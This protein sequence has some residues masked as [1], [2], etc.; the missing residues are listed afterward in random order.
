MKY[1]IDRVLAQLRYLAD[2]AGI[3]VTDSSAGLRVLAVIALVAAGAVVYQVVDVTTQPTQPYSVHNFKVHPRTV[4]QPDPTASTTQPATQSSPPQADPGGQ[5]VVPAQ[6]LLATLSHN[7]QSYSSP[8]T[9]Q[10]LATVPAT[11]HGAQSVLPVI[12]QS[13]QFYQVRLAQ[14]PNGSTAWVKASD[15]KITQTPYFI[16]VDLFTTKL[17]FYKAGSQIG[18]YPAGVGTYADP[19]PTGNYFGAFDAAPEGPGYGP[20]IM[21]TSAHSDVIQD[22]SSSGDAMI[23][24]HGPL[25]SDRA[26]GSTGAHIT[27]GCIRLHESDQVQLRIVPTGTPVVV[28]A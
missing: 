7:T 9:K 5:V 25:G 28:I 23:A 10:P 12:T 22:W 27:H 4:A 24:I 3:F 26:I 2:R 1:T 18:V 19:T 8:T 11:W 13:G 6:T 14:R 16:V 17:T 20:F 15:V 21:A